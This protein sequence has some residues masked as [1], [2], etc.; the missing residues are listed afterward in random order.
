MLR[1]IDVNQ[2]A[3]FLHSIT[4]QQTVVK[5]ALKAWFIQLLKKSVEN[6]P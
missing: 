1:D 5:V 3:S 4:P 2:F 6:V